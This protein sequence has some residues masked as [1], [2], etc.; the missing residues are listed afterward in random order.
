[1]S[2]IDTAANR[3][4]ERFQV[5][6]DRVLACLERLVAAFT[7]DLLEH[8]QDL[9]HALNRFPLALFDDALS[10]LPKE[11]AVRLNEEE[12]LQQLARRARVA[13]WLV[14][15]YTPYYTLDELA[16][17]TAKFRSF[18]KE[19]QGFLVETGLPPRSYRE[20][21]WLYRNLARLYDTRATSSPWPS[22]EFWPRDKPIPNPP[23]FPHFT[24]VGGRRAAQPDLSAIPKPH[25]T[26]GSRLATLG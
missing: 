18:L 5:P 10:A 7:S 20:C 26:P 12:D 3:L 22:D 25:P 14:G 24:A 13:E 21:R 11:V 2:V 17:H 9:D 23:P 6:I 4:A 8:P 16:E 1:V 19:H 15:E